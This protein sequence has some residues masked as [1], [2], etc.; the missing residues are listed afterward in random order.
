MKSSIFPI[1]ALAL[2]ATAGAAAKDKDGNAEMSERAAAELAKF[3]RTG[4]MRSCLNLTSIREIDAIDERL[5]LVRVGGDEYYM[6]AFSTRCTGAGQSW[7][8]IQYE[9][10]LAQL[11][12][13]QIIKVVDT[14]NGSVQGSCGL[15]QFE[16][17]IMKPPAENSADG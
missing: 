8:H 7:N 6:N 13:N 10:G 16:R 12:S 1:V 2:A 3:E 14:A 15:N 4:E 9:T 5:L 17:L 11:C